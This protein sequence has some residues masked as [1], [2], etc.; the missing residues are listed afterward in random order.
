M[1]R[2]ELFITALQLPVDF[3]LLLL[4]AVS[5]YYLR[6]SGWAVAWK[7][8]LFNISLGDYISL[9]LP[10][11]GVWIVIFAFAGLYSTDPNRKLLPELQKVVFACSSGLA[12]VALY[13]MFRQEVF[14]S[15]FLVA[16][17]WLFAIVYVVAGRIMMRLFKRKLYKAGIGSRRI[18]VIGH[19][20]TASEEI[21]N[22]LKEHKEM[23][24]IIAGQ[25]VHF[26]NYTV[27]KLN[28]LQ[29]DEVIFTNPRAHE[30]ETLSAI[31]YCNEHQ[32][33]FKY[34]ADL[35]DTF[36][37][38]MRVSPLAGI[39]IVELR[40]TPLEGWARILKRIFDILA[41]VFVIIITGP[42]MILTTLF[43]LFETGFPVI[44]KNERVGLKSKNFFTLKF[45]SMY[46]K[47]C[48]GR[49]FGEEGAHAEERERELIREQSIKDG[50]IYKIANDPRVTKVGRFIRR[51][52][53]DELPQFFNVLAGNMSVVG[54]RPHQPREVDKYN[55]QHK[56][57]LSL[58]PGITGLAQISG[59]S[60]L[61]FEE[62]IKLDIFYIEK[63]SL[64]IDLVIFIKTPFVLFKKRK[65]A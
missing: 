47:D 31:K 50:P 45:R 56:Y 21:I 18:A 8:I 48:T 61:S 14:D 36:S 17:S 11:A 16:A 3:L 38:N 42:I 25:F 44:Y 37:S 26:D 53:I 46:K 49:Q 62:E 57:V 33:V 40:S 27:E 55:S 43:I 20:G 22:F 15:R 60:D 54:P 64:W 9:A 65:V 24:Y 39:P 12:V 4:A 34:S 28:E 59:R 10:I 7:Q 30:S 1:K 5:A 58:K 63:W 13:I 23:G 29:L 19:H 52:S 51:W 32:I 6:F 35:F 2:S 41:S